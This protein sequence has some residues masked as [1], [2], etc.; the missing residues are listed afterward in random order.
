MNKYQKFLSSRAPILEH[1]VKGG[2]L[3]ASLEMLCLAAEA[4]EPSMRCSILFYDATQGKVLHGAAPNLPDAYNNAVHGLSVS[5][6]V[7]SCG[8]AATTGERIIVED[9]FNHSYWED[10]QGLAKETGFSACWS[11]PFFATTGEVLGTFAMYYD[12]PKTPSPTDISLIEELANIASIATQHKRDSDELI[13]TKNKLEE[14]LNITETLIVELNTQG[15]VAAINNHI[16]QVLGYNADQLIGSNWFDIAVPKTQRAEVKLVFSRIIQGD[17]TSVEYYENEILTKD[18]ST[19]FISWHNKLLKDQDNNI[20]GTLSSGQDITVRKQTAQQLRRSERMKAV[21][22]LTSGIAHDFNNMLS[23]AI[24]NTE[25]AQETLKTP[26]RSNHFLQKAITAMERGKSLTDSL[27]SF[28]DS[29]ARNETKLVLN[30]FINEIKPILA[31]QLKPNVTTEYLLFDKLWPICVSPM[32]LENCL[33]ILFRNANDALLE[34]GK[35][36]VSIANRPDLT[37]KLDFVEQESIPTADYIMISVHDMGVGMSEKTKRHM[38]EP[39]FTTK[40]FGAGAGLS[41]SSA[42][43]FIRRSGGYIDVVSEL[44]KGTLI[45]LYFPKNGKC[46]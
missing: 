36:T 26:E 34:G 35:I 43:G 30:P 20:S 33:T 46:T 7:G 42:Y 9:V 45:K 23:V 12:R 15:Q 29:N 24:G 19:R 28:S 37:G 16:L 1:I 41:L 4:L 18:G 13:K 31:D 21:G 17:I 38:F 5:P 40:N 27:L 32:E 3:G 8:T 22:Q 2:D 6:G 39:F 14:Y 11:Q 25:M 10:F 44:G